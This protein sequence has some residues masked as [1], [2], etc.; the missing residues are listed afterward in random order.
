MSIGGSS[1]FSLIN[2]GAFITGM[3]IYLKRP[4]KD[5]IFLRAKKVKDHK[6]GALTSL[7]SAEEGFKKYYG[8]LQ[9]IGETMKKI[10]DEAIS[11]GERN[12]QETLIDAEYIAT[13]L[14]GQSMGRIK[15]EVMRGN[16]MFYREVV[17]KSVEGAEQILKERLSI[18]T[19][20]KLCRSFLNRLSTTPPIARSI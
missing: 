10:M 19:Q 16:K 2:L 12:G 7:S 11:E 8:Q 14:V 18:D 15:Y 20:L 3:I 4:V 9:D 17:E 5:Y 6:D 13:R 1:I